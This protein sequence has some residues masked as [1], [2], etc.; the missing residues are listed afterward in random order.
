MSISY[1]PPSAKLLNTVWAMASGLAGWL[2]LRLLA[3][4]FIVPPSL[5]LPP[6][7]IVTVI[8][9]APSGWARFNSV[10][11]SAGVSATKCNS[12]KGRSAAYST[13]CSQLVAVTRPAT[14][15]D[16]GGGGGGPPPPGPPPPPPGGLASSSFNHA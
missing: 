3:A 13:S 12:T 5:R 4:K 14:G 15:V 1:I 8:C 16:G 11:V 2:G 9:S 6:T 10:A 7:D